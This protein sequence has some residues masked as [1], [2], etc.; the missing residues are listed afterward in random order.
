M[1]FRILHIIPRLRKGGAER[2]C[3]DSDIRFMVKLKSPN[4]RKINLQITEK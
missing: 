3:L 4:N 1:K 2:L